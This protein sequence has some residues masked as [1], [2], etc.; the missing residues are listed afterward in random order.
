MIYATNMQ[1]GTERSGEYREGYIASREKQ[2]QMQC[3]FTLK[4]DTVELLKKNK[5]AGTGWLTGNEGGK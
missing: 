4:S 5:Y 3:P 2:P 1:G